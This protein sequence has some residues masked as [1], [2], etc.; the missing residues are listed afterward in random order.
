MNGALLKQLLIIANT[1]S[2]NTSKLAQAT[3]LGATS[4][5][6]DNVSVRLLQPLEADAE[7][8]LKADGIIIGTTENFGY[9]AGLIK[10]FLE[11]IYYPCLEK[12][13]GLPYGLYIRAGNDGTGTKLAIGKIITGL[14][15]KA[16]EEPLIL[17]G[18][19]DTRFCDN[20]H[21]LGMLM[22]AGLDNN[23]F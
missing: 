9:M 5:E 22:A 14:R 15:W 12:K 23:I 19:F 8:V 21:E 18:E 20:C 13:Q 3:L 16:V 11:R 6:I 7:D 10:D 1:P 2:E 4:D 17:R